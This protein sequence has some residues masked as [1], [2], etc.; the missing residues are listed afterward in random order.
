MAQKMIQHRTWQNAIIGIYFD[1][2][3]NIK[4]E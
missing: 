1:N 2:S 3:E 4:P